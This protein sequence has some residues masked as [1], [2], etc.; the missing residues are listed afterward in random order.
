MNINPVI[1]FLIVLGCMLA[2]V[3]LALSVGYVF[4]HV[5]AFPDQDGF[6]AVALLILLGLGGFLG[7]ISIFSLISSWIGIL[8]PK[9]AFGLPEGSV[10]AILTMAFIVIVG[11]LAS[12]LLTSSKGNYV[13][14]RENPLTLAMNLPLEDARDFINATP[15]TDGVLAIRPSA[16]VLTPP[17]PS[18]GPPAPAAGQPPPPPATPPAPPAGAAGPGEPRYDVLLFPRLDNRLAEDVSKQILTMLS[19]ILAAM[20][21]FYFGARPGESDPDA[22]KRAQSVAEIERT[23]ASL[24][25]TDDLISRAQQLVDDKVQGERSESEARHADRSD[26]RI[27]QVACDDRLRRQRAPLSPTTAVEMSNSAAPPQAPQRDRGR[28][29]DQDLAK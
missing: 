18:A 21:G 10:R 3:A 12:Y 17:E 11:V 6:G 24:P 20:I 8:D 28:E 1:N 7:L 4:Y 27:T 13:V 9:Q 25:D 23:V 5:L 19:T 22:V 26:R 14:D 29:N 16:F 2:G 15:S